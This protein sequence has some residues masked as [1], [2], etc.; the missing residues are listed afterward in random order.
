M[1]ERLSH[2]QKFDDDDIWLSRS[3]KVQPA[4]AATI[5]SIFVKS[6]GPAPSAY[7]VG[8]RQPH[9]PSALAVGPAPSLA[10]G[11]PRSVHVASHG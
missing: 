1:E 4:T 6:V 10:H 9:T 8:P 5:K 7:A 11:A 2:V 3:V